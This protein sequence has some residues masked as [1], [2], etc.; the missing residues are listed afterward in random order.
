MLSNGSLQGYFVSMSGAGEGVMGASWLTRLGFSGQKLFMLHVAKVRS[1]DLER[2]LKRTPRGSSSCWKMIDDDMV[3]KDDGGLLTYCSNKS[4]NSALIYI[5]P[6][7][8]QM[9]FFAFKNTTLVF[10]IYFRY[11]LCHSVPCVRFPT[12]CLHWLN[13]SHKCGTKCHRDSMA[14]CQVEHFM[15]LVSLAAANASSAVLCTPWGQT[16]SIMLG[17]WI[18]SAQK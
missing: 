14:A 10:C 12:V 15:N 6:Q 3:N 17:E 1:R 18:Y 7:K 2:S 8:S 5:E 16:V 4:W 11:A 9:W 13:Q